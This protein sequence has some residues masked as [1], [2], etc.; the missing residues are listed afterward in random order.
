MEKARISSSQHAHEPRAARGAGK[1][2]A[3][4]Q[5]AEQA[6]GTS[7]GFSLLLASLSDG[8]EPLSDGF[9]TPVTAVDWAAIGVADA[10]QLAAFQSGLPSGLP[11]GAPWQ[12]AGEHAPTAAGRLLGDGLGG[13]K[14][15][16]NSLVG[17]TAM[18]DGAAETAAVNGTAVP[19]SGA[20]P[21]RGAAGGRQASFSA[22]AGN[23]AATRLDAALNS[24][25]RGTAKDDTKGA[26][27][28]DAGAAFSLAPAAAGALSAERRDVVPGH[29]GAEARGFTDGATALPA[30]ALAGL[31]DVAAGSGDGRSGGRGGESAGNGA[32][33]SAAL[34]VGEPGAEPSGADA[35]FSL[36]A[37]LADPAQAGMEDQL[38]EQVAFWV[39]QKTQNAELTLDRDG[40]PVEV[41]VSLT[42]NEAHVSFRSDQAQT[43]ELLDASVAQLRDLLQSE[44]L[45]LAG[46]SVG[47]SGGQ[48]AR[49]GDAPRDGGRQGAREATVRAAAPAGTAGRAQVATDRSVDIF[50]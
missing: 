14:A 27:A 37:A 3:S 30:G 50:V 48:G 19:G 1:P 35:A 5:N 8:S 15:G 45:Q 38:A 41:T 28:A 29:P 40:Q 42:G 33:P 10:A 36:D 13:G 44:G 6:T 39:N 22:A 32:S 26:G 34:A 46:V 12:S 43:R 7:G 11:P 31:A 18:L 24:A 4:S 20:A 25:L 2:S 21:G 17:Q 16:L 49:E 23:D 9:A 47:T